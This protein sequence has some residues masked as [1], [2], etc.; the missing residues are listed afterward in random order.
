LEK[1]EGNKGICSQ[2]YLKQVL[3]GVIFLYWEQM[4]EDEQTKYIFIED[5][6]KIY[7]GY[8]YLP[9]LNCNI[10]TFDWLLSLP[11]LNPIEKV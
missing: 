5:G 1:E 4:S 6:S 3:E 7:K 11:D 8:I 9:K 2:V 10:R